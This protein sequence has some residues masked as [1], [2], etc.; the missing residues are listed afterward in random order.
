M[1]NRE[2]TLI[3][4]TPEVLLK[5]YACGIFP[6]A[7]SAEDPALYWIEPEMRGIIPLDGFHVA[8]RLARTV[9]TTPFTVRVDRDFDGVI[10]G[11]AEAKE[12]RA[13]TWINGRIRKIYRSLYEHGHAHSV[14]VYDGDALVGGLYGVSL[15]RAF[16]GES[17]FHRARDASKIALVHLVARLRAGGYRLLDTQYVTD[18]LMTFGAV[19]VAKRRY[20]RLLEDAIASDAD[21]AALPVDASISGAEALALLADRTI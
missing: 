1:A 9:R 10:E 11:C 4:I 14:E 20:H 5:A 15:G 3:E 18:H 12:N 17:M 2:S 7:E 19:E 6:M 21:F 8:S 16:F 13:K